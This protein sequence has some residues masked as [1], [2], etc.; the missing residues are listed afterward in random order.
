M[1]RTKFKVKEGLAVADDV[2][3]GGFDLIPSGVLMPYAGSVAPTGWLL[4]NGQQVSR[5]TYANLYAVVGTT[6]GTGDGS[7]TFHVP[8]LRGRA[9][10]GAGTGAQDGNSGTGAIS[11]GTALTS[12]SLGAWGGQETMTISS[13][14]LPTHQHT[15]T[16]DANNFNTGGPS[17]N[18]S[19]GPSINNTGYISANHTHDTNVGD[20]GNMI[21]SSTDSEVS[22]NY[23]RHKYFVS[24]DCGSGTARARLTSSGAGY[25]GSGIE[26]TILD[27]YHGVGNKTS[28]TVSS[29]HLHDLQSHTHGMK[30]HVH[31]ANHGHTAS[32]SGTF[33]NTATPNMAPFLVLNYIIKY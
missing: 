28:G 15:V 1:A 17:D 5:T 24:T 3:S 23:H 26:Y 32:T 10:V 29:N 16:V 21:N 31:N 14:N 27:H 9:I 30:S 20:T 19:D 6:Y 25:G 4:C 18:T 22:G 2:Q 33:S 12:R 7:S 8:D 11:G 13:T